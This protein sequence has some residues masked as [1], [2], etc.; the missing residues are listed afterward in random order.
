MGRALPDHLLALAST[1]STYVPLEKTA[2]QIRRVA[3]EGDVPRL[4]RL[5]TSLRVRYPASDNLA[6]CLIHPE[7]YSRNP[8]LILAAEK[9]LVDVVAWLLD[10]GVEEGGMSQVGCS[11][12][13]DA[14]DVLY[15]T[16][17]LVHLTVPHRTQM[18]TTSYT[19]QLQE[20]ARKSSRCTTLALLMSMIRL[21]RPLRPPSLRSDQAYRGCSHIAMMRAVSIS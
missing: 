1:R 2:E 6:Q 15:L 3:L 17:A 18:A 4:D 10:Q 13:I 21:R 12:H 14:E 20:V 16:Q 19:S 7:L 8:T 11:L 5:W 9:K